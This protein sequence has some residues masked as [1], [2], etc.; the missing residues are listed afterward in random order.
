MASGDGGERVAGVGHAGNGSQALGGERSVW[1]VEEFPYQAP[2]HVPEDVA[3]RGLEVGV[4]ILGDLAV[5]DGRHVRRIGKFVGLGQ[6][7]V[8][9]DA[10]GVVVVDHGLVDAEGNDPGQFGF[11]EARDPGIVISPVFGRSAL[12]TLLGWFDAREGLLRA[13]AGPLRL[14]V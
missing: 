13:I 3:H 9:A 6:V 5:D 11:V 2:D 1:G 14:A 4:L 12:L 8:Q 10:V 7:G